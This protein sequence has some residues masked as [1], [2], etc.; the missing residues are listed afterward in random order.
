MARL[1]I[2]VEGIVQGVGMRPFVY[3]AAIER[4]LVGWVRNDPSALRIEVQGARA[5]VNAFL[6]AL[7][8]R[9]PSA[10]RIERLAITEIDERPD[11]DFR[12]LSSAQEGRAGPVLPPDLAPC[13]A[14]T[15]EV[16]TPGARRFRYPFTNCTACGPRAT[17]VEALP[18]DRA[19]TSMKVFAMCV[20]C[21]REYDDPQDRRFHAQ[22]IACPACGPT[23]ELLSADGAPT[24]RGDE[25]LRRAVA[26]V[27]E[28][29]VVALQGVGGFQLLADATNEDAVTRLRA[30]KRREAKPLAVLF[31]SLDEVA[32]RCVLSRDEE[33]ALASPEAPIV[34]VA[35]RAGEALA[36]S[37]APGHPRLGA[38]L[39][40]SPLHRLLAEDVSRPLVCTSGNVSDEPMCV[41]TQEALERLRGIADAFLVHDRPIVR[42]MDD[43]VARL[44]GARLTVLRRARGLAPRPLRVSE[45]TGTVLALGGQLKS[46]V[47]L[48]KNGEIVVSQHLGDLHSLEGARLHERTARELPA[49]FGARLDA[50]ACDL[51][52]DYAST[53]LAERLAVELGVPLVRVQHHHAHVAACIAEH[54][55][56][57]PVLGFAWD[58]AGYGLDGTLW[59]GEVLLCEGHEFRR[60][61]HLRPFALPGGERAMV[62]PRRAAL[63][64][65]HEVLG[66]DAE[67]HVAAMFARS[68]A[69]TLLTM[70]ERS[71]NAPRTTS[72]GRLFDA[73][74]ALVSAV[75]GG[76]RIRYEGEAA[77]ALEVAAASAGED[78][79]YPLDAGEGTPS[80]ADWEPLVVA[81]L[82]DVA[83]GTAIGIVSA[84]FHEALAAFAEAVAVKSGVESVV[85][86]GGCFQNAVLT[87]RVRQR[88]SARGHRVYTPVRYPSNDGGLS[89][90]QALVASRWLRRGG[91]HDVPRDPR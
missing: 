71:V 25:A 33:Q 64:L 21:R 46:T 86:S 35:R 11:V 50:V 81:L 76:R 12:I 60:V 24:A 36:A 72:V 32:R 75:P 31:S 13:A 74:A 91:D 42:A 23:L 2:V 87:S 49:F 15:D 52:P 83:R 47:A 65:L 30:R 54:G 69:R 40:A 51:H 45:A 73:V 85:L 44:D 7:E 5:R 29:G 57:G 56:T 38:M 58:G 22:P 67:R 1:S 62:E 77:M 63:G 88:L 84:R 37:I 9:R 79:G 28:G 27:V 48:A 68:E 6:D 4:A 89:L 59:G 78:G 90:G 26:C 10:A 14:C 3:R 17:I 16:A 39:A 53:R 61:A 66:A 80:V 18:Y 19:R 20:D 82:A 70:I 43:S 41:D 34:L 8:Q 55:L